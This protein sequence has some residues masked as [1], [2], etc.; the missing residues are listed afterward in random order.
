MRSRILFLIYNILSIS[1]FQE[2]ATVIAR[3]QS[4]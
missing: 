2:I 1:T 3:G 4:G